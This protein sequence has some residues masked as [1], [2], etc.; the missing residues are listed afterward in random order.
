MICHS[1]R[2]FPVQSIMCS[3]ICCFR[4]QR[5]FARSGIPHQHEGNIVT[6]TFQIGVN[7]GRKR[8]GMGIIKQLF[9]SA[10]NN[11][12]AIVETNDK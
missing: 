7:L 1:P 11:L 10:R 5:R 8:E 3:D 4:H 6:D 2:Y 9:G 12:H